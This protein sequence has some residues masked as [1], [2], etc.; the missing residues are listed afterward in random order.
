MGFFWKQN[1]QYV[2][3]DQ[4]ELKSPFRIAHIIIG[5]IFALGLLVFSVLIQSVLFEIKY[6]KERKYAKTSSKIDLEV[7]FG[8][9]FLV[10]LTIVL[11]ILTI[12][13]LEFKVRFK[14]ED[15][16]EDDSSNE[17]VG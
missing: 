7:I 15:L 12:A 2:F 16:I 1:N 14:Q 9:T 13:F 3:Y 17:L 8:Q 10:V 11:I 6:S 5:I 4:Y